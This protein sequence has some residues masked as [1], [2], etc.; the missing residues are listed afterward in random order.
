M[1]WKVTFLCMHHE[2]KFGD[3]ISWCDIPCFAIN[4][5]ISQKTERKEYEN[6][7]SEFKF[8]FGQL[9]AMQP[10]AGSKCSVL[11]TANKEY[12]EWILY[13]LYKVMIKIK[14]NDMFIHS[15][16]KHLLS[17]SFLS[18]TVQGAEDI[19]EHNALPHRA[20]IHVC[21]MCVRMCVWIHTLKRCTCI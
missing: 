13:S 9:L 10:W 15:S 17:F 18:G 7:K 20:Y 14:W 8:W 12:I 21:A 5:A 1:D 3:K 16:N 6:R 4:A 19:V 2:F 11:L